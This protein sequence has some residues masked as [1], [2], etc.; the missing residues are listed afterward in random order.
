MSHAITLHLPAD[1][2]ALPYAEGHGLDRCSFLVGLVAA[3]LLTLG[4]AMPQN[5]GVEPTGGGKTPLADPAIVFIAA[6]AGTQN[7][8]VMN[9]DGSNRTVVTSFAS[10]LFG[11]PKW[12]PDGTRICFMLHGRLADNVYQ[13]GLALLEVAVVNGAVVSRNARWLVLDIDY[14]IPAWSPDGAYIAY[15]H[16]NTPGIFKIPVGGGTPTAIVTDPGVDW[17]PISFSG[18]GTRI[19]YRQ[20]DDVGN[21]WLGILDLSNL[22]STQVCP[23]ST[24]LRNID[25]ART[26]DRILIDPR[27]STGVAI[28]IVE[29]LP[30]SVPRQVV[31]GWFPS[32]SP[33]D[34]RI[35]YTGWSTSDPIIIRNLATGT[36]TSTGAKGRQIDWRKF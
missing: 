33:D 28:S 16:A 22:S 14:P 12:S 25:W 4:S 31:K 30:N 8:T 10:G 27:D 15:T 29:A 34:S 7:L 6:S 17:A 21:T 9:A 23:L 11:K 36:V 13:R 32:W 35:V 1:V 26:G 3:V 2:A 20:R 19:A 5:K 24:D 18:D